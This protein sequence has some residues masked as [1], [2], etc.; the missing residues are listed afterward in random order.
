MNEFKIDT[1]E[2]QIRLESYTINTETNCISSYI[3]IKRAYGISAEQKYPSG[4]FDY[5]FIYRNRQAVQKQWR[6][7]EFFYK[8]IYKT[9]ELCR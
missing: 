6:I 7:N 8:L 5:Y 3:R 4:D 2:K 1:L 9:I